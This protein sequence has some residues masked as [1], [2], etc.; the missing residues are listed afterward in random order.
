MSSRN[1][2]A[3][4]DRIDEEHFE[5]RLHASAITALQQRVLELEAAVRDLRV[6][7]FGGPKKTSPTGGPVLRQSK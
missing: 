5:L 7:D 2:A 6:E 1:I 4:H 3:L